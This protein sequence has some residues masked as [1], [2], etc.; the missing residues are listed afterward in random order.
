M[1]KKIISISLALFI[2]SFCFTSC[3]DS[4]AGTDVQIIMPIDSDPLYLDP[5]ICSSTAALNIINNCFDGLVDEDENGEIVTA[6]AESYTISDD[7]LTYTF[8][9]RDDLQWKMTT[10]ASN[11][12]LNEDGTSSFDTQITAYDFA[13]ALERAVSTETQAPF[14]SSLFS[15][16]NA[17]EIYNGEKDVSSLGVTVISD[18]VLEI[19]LESVDLDFLHT[20]TTAIAM[21]C[22][23]EFF[24]ATG[25]RYGLSTTYLIYN[26]AFYIS[27]WSDNTAITATKNTLYYDYENVMPSSIYF[28]INDEYSTRTTKVLNGTYEVSPILQSQLDELDG[29]KNAQVYSFQSSTLS[30]FFNCEDTYLASTSLRQAIV[31]SLDTDVLYSVI[32]GTIADGILPSTTSISSESFKYLRS[33]LAMLEYDTA[34]SSSLY[35]EFLEKLDAYTIELSIICTEEYESATRQL[36]QGWQSAMGISFNIS[37]EVLDETELNSRVSSGDYQIALA[38]ITFTGSTAYNA[39]SIFTT[40]SPDNVFNFDSNDFNDIMSEAKNSTTVV[41]M[42]NSLTQAEQ[43]LISNAV[44]VP[45][46]EENIYYG[47]GSNVSGVY[48]N[49]TG[50]IVTFKYALSP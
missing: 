2:L 42:A 28:S 47:L 44:I 7:G 10:S 32:D 27:G 34:L 1:F 8:V 16:K 21:P 36:I 9:L 46:F 18:L 19:Q 6:C 17:E 4:V 48:F 20:L 29:N 50:E 3:S 15:I 13:F 23:E 35:R 30:L 14:V 26:G 24:E 11:L 45:L 25:G 12:M 43:Y 22:S 40:D 5:Q 38:N 31:Y 39:L 49:S 41:D 33:G 37:V